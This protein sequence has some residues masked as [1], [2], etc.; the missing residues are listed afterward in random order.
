M[1]K[2]LVTGGSGFLGRHVVNRLVADGH[3]VVV[4]TRRRERAK[5]LIVLPAVDVLEADIHDE[6]TLGR[7]VARCDAVVNL[8]G[9]LHSRSGAPYGPAFERAHVELLRKLV[10]ACTRASVRRVIHVSAIGATADAPSE[11]LRSKAAGEEILLAARD[12]IDATV[13]RPS[14]IFGPDDRF[15]NVFAFLQRWS[16]MLFVASPDAR[17]QPVFVG[18]VAECIARAIADPLIARDSAHRNYDLGGPKQYT[19]RELVALAGRVSGHRRPIFGLG[20]SL[21]MLQAWSLE[22][23][24]VKL[25]SRDNIRSMKVPS[26]CDGPLPFGI[27]PVS[28]EAFAPTYLAG[29]FS[30]ARYQTFR[31]QAGR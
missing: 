24:P 1:A 29:A 7:L 17:V 4:P 26:V 19:L 6:A 27:K 18:D 14:V 22:L 9:V 30:R 5:H 28:L 31:N 20:E 11:Y 8:V 25:M 10:E 21:S 16:P 15:M 2:I 12:K 3:S 23:L 13:F